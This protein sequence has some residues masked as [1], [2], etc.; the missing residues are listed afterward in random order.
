MSAWLQLLRISNLPTAWANILMGFLLAQQTWTPAGELIALLLAS[1]CFY[2]A[3]MVLNDV[4]DFERDVKERPG[5][6][7]P[8]EK[9]SLTAARR[10]GF[11]ML[12][13]GVLMSGVAGWLASGELGFVFTRCLAIGI[14]LAAAVWLYDGALK[15]TPV[16]AGVMGSCRFL[17]V[18]LGA[19]T[20]GSAEAQF[21]APLVEL[22]WAVIWVAASLGVLIAGVT[23]LGRNEAKEKQNRMALILAGFII[24][25]GA[26][27][28]ATIVF[29]PQDP[30]V[31]NLLKQRFPW[32]VVLIA[33]PVI[34]NV[35]TAIAVATPASIQRGVISVL[36]SLIFLDA[37][38]CYVSKPGE[39]VYCLVVLSLMVP[40]LLMKRTIKMT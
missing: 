33:I 7:L 36:S 12:F 15:K 4:F 16:A 20:F 3:G 27:G 21:L 10:T 29:C 22:P 38:I 1:S 8:A 31:S 17:N 9:I 35:L 5:R 23:L 37:A 2:L 24:A 30:A 13:L 26:A 18:L 39:V 32:L 28:F 14:A 11:G 34:R 19:S 6:P 25:V 40:V